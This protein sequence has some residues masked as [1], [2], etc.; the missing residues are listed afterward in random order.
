M[1]SGEIGFTIESIDWE[2]PL[3]DETR[4][5]ILQLVKHHR[6]EL[7][8][9]N[10][11]FSSDEYVLYLNQKYLQHEDYTDILTFNYSTAGTKEI[12]GD[13]FI[14]VERVKDNAETYKVPFIDELHRVMA[15]G[16]LHI[17]GYDDTT[18]EA[19]Q[20]MRQQEEFALQLRMF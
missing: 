9:L 13:I 12:I 19:E 3:P 1:T 8:E 6:H 2:L 7:R 20:Q 11:I 4:G 10:F 15:H 18:D 17:V 16:I 5:W 14:S